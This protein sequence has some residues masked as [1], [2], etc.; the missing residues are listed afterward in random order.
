M[1]EAVASQIL[2]ADHMVASKF[3]WVYC[4]NT[5]VVEEEL[6]KLVLRRCYLEECHN[7]IGVGVGAILVLKYNDKLLTRKV[8]LWSIFF[9]H[10]KNMQINFSSIQW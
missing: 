7:Y 3:H 9:M 10:M 6:Q 4:K 8:N 5:L 2:E 1:L